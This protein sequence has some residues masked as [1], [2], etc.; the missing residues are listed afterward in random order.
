MRQDVAGQVGD[1]LVVRTETMVE[2]DLATQVRRI[3]S[4]Y[5]EIA[6]DGRVRKQVVEW[7]FRFTYRFEAEH[8]LER[9]GFE[10]AGVYG[11][12]QREPFASESKWLV[13]LG[14]RQT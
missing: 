8:L 6:S 10:I 5:E 9:A 3:R 13:L 2:T 14:R 7:P 11:G 4:V 1:S 12:H